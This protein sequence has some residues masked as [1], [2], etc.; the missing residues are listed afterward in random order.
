MVK[1][2]AHAPLG[3]ESVSVSWLSGVSSSARGRPRRPANAGRGPR[4]RLPG[5]R[6]ARHHR[7]MLTKPTFAMSPFFR[8][9]YATSTEEL[10]DACTRIQRFCGSVR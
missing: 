3:D 8:I 10:T 5:R 2:F 7:A 6:R 4:L 9:S 1:K